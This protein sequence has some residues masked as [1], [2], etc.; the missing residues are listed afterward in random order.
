M[1]EINEDSLNFIKNKASEIAEYKNN[2][3]ENISLK[4]KLKLINSLFKINT[5]KNIIFNLRHRNPIKLLMIL[6]SIERKD[7]KYKK[8]NN[9]ILNFTREFRKKYINNKNVC[10]T[11][12]KKEILNEIIESYNKV[13]YDIIIN[14]KINNK[15]LYNLFIDNDEYNLFFNKNIESIEYYKNTIIVKFENCNKIEFELYLT[16]NKITNN[17]PFKY[18]IKLMVIN[19]IIE[20]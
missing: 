15:N 10:F 8:F 7:E 3:W 6:Y 20:I 4:F 17:L 13:I 16:S 2:N 12:F 11:N 5:D 1:E 19:T 18:R 9:E 14:D